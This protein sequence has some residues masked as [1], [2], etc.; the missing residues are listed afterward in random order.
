MHEGMR[1]QYL[2]IEFEQL[3]DALGRKDELIEHLMG[4]IR[5]AP[6]LVARPGELTY[7]CRTESPCRVCQWRWEVN[8]GLL[9][10]WDLPDGIWGG[11]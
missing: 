7:E 2:P 8:E 1:L 5:N 6:C 9:E 10:G 4:C 3:R 11:K